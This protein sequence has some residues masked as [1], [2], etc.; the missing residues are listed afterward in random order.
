MQKLILLLVIFCMT[1]AAT[2]QHTFK[3]IIKDNSQQPLEG[4]TVT[5]QKSKRS[6]TS[7][8]S[9]SVLLTGIPNGRQTIICSGVGFETIAQAYTFPLADTP[10]IVITMETA[11]DELEEVIIRSTRTSRNIKNVPTRVETITG[12]EIDEKSNMRPANVSMLLHESTGMQVQQTSATTASA[13]IRIQGLDGRYSQLLKDGFANYAGFSGGL[14]VLEIPPLDL[15]QV[16]IIKGPASTLYGGGAIAGV[17]NFISKEPGEKNYTDLLFNQSHI[18]QTNLGLFTAQKKNKIGFTLL[19]LVNFQQAYDVDKDDFTELP[20]AREVTVIPRLFWYINDKTVFDISHS[21]TTGHRSGGDIFVVKNQGDALHTYFE[22]NNSIRNITNLQLEKKIDEKNHLLIKQSFNFY[23]RSI[24]VP[25]YRFKGTQ[26]NMFTDIAYRHEAVRH[27]IIGGANFIA[28]RFKEDVTYS[29]LQRNEQNN[30]LGFYLQDTWMV[31]SKIS[32]ENGLRADAI[33]GFGPFVL[34]RISILYKIN[35][36]WSSRAGVGLGYKLPTLFTEAAEAIQFRQIAPLQNNVA[37]KSV[38]GTADINWRT[39]LSPLLEFGLNQLFFYTRIN[40]PLIL[41]SSNS[42]GYYFA[43]ATQPVRAYGFETNARFVYR[44]NWKLFLGYTFNETRAEYASGNQVLPIVP[45][46]KLNTALIY[47]KHD[48]LKAGLEA[49]YTGPQ[50]ISNG[51]RT[52]S[53]WELGLMAEKPFKRF[54]VFINAENITD[55]RQSRYKRVVNGPHNNPG[56]DEIWTHTE[57]F[58]LN[59]GVKVHL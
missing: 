46:H 30:T 16:E 13:S 14:S 29:G 41:Q 21:F 32:F 58:V 48:V 38:G 9:G 20:K 39:R 27:T 6:T 19:G 22:T 40:R 5:L 59:G 4:I 37:E 45:K 17:V 50:F 3:A 23:T 33:N 56:F 12:E 51:N 35:E 49:Y 31:S 28:N 15:Q 43:N 7:N 55:V 52:P 24:T 2:G 57:G 8:A 36:Q 44:S 18:G 42:G 11:E 1:I 26:Q 53:F 54:S 10:V 47:E 25:G 34:P